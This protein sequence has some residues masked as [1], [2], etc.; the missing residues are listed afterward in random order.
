[1]LAFFMLSLNYLSCFAVENL[2]NKYIT[3]SKIKDKNVYIVKLADNRAGL[4][5]ENDNIIIHCEYNF[6]RVY[7]PNE[8]EKYV[9]YNKDEVI[10]YNSD[11]GLIN[12]SYK[13]YFNDQ[14][15]DNLILENNGKFGL[16]DIAK[17][18]FVL[19]FEYDNIQNIA[20]GT[21]L[22]EK[23][24]KKGIFFKNG[25]S[26]ECVYREIKPINKDTFFILTDEEN[27]QSLLPKMNSQPV[28]SNAED[29]SKELCNIANRYF[30][31][32]KR[33]GKYG[34]E[35]YNKGTGDVSVAVPYL[36]EDITNSLRYYNKSE[37]IFFVCKKDGKYGLVNGD[38]GEE[39]S[40]FVYDSI[41]NLKNS[42]FVKVEQNNKFGYYNLKNNKVS[43][44]H[45]DDVGV[46]TFNGFCLNDA[47][48][49]KVL[50]GK[51]LHNQNKLK[52]A[53]LVLAE[54]CCD[55]VAVPVAILVGAPFMITIIVLAYRS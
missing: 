24:S 35:E 39:L 3:V 50:K 1:M 48:L 13:P 43:K 30:I 32:V 20:N 7:S 31:I 9:F 52:H 53:G 21:F 15:R 49:I 19:P 16:Y 51:H 11:K 4:V 46:D 41:E 27:R 44:I 33:D 5:D 37:N 47:T 2:G 36:Y 34:V 38:T 18:K 28:I 45:Y 54:T 22:F 55:I 8:S 23:D 12:L 42:G 26:T 40:D 14:E 29:I 17:E 25:I 6:Y 10:V